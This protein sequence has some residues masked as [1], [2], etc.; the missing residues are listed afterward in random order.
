MRIPLNFP[1]LKTGYCHLCHP[2]VSTLVEVFRSL[3]SKD[4]LWGAKP[5][6]RYLQVLGRVIRPAVLTPLDS[7][8]PLTDI[9]DW[10]PRFPPIYTPL[11][12][13]PSRTR[14]GK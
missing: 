4:P 14:T 12:L 1:C 11:K 9:C 5:V 3:P 2:C 8:C 13:H 10:P 7:F 6:R